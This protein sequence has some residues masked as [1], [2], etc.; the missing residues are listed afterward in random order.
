MPNRNGSSPWDLIQNNLGLFI[1]VLIFTAGFIYFFTN[2]ILDSTNLGEV[3]GIRKKEVKLTGILLNKDD[4]KPITEGKVWLDND[5]N[6][7]TN[8]RDNGSFS[9]FDINIPETHNITL[10]FQRTEGSP[11]YNVYS[12][13]LKNIK[14]DRYNKETYTYNLSSIPVTLEETEE[15]DLPLGDSPPTQYDTNTDRIEYRTQNCLPSDRDCAQV[16]LT[17]GNLNMRVQPSN[18]SDIVDKIPNGAY[19]RVLEMTSKKEKIGDKI[20]R[21]LYVMYQGKMGYV[22]GA[23]VKYNEPTLAPG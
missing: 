19:V 8:L 12:E 3:I 23:Y 2:S 10:V 21:W 4:R 15:P 22:F 14:G 1:G 11:V 7:A 17:G 20:D 18:K 6:N 5:S 13:N 9:L 16:D